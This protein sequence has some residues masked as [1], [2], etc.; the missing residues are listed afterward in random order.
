MLAFLLLLH[1]SE[2]LVLPASFFL[3]V[4]LAL[5]FLATRSRSSRPNLRN[6]QILFAV[7]FGFGGFVCLLIALDEIINW[8]EYSFGLK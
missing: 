5:A 8:I 6:M 4:A 7:V 3:L 2:I 1:G